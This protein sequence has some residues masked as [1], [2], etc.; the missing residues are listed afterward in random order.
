M[1]TFEVILRRKKTIQ[2]LRHVH[3]LSRIPRKVLTWFQ[4]WKKS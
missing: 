2:W 1:E 3:N 4:K